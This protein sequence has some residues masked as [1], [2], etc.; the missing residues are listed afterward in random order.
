MHYAYKQGEEAYMQIV[1]TGHMIPSQ[2]D[3]LIGMNSFVLPK[4]NSFFTQK[5]TT[6]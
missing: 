5:S 6:K 4:K 1:G 3:R 2:F